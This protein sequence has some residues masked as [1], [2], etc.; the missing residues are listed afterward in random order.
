MRRPPGFLDGAPGGFAGDAGLDDAVDD[1]GAGDAEVC[2][3][4]Q[5]ATI[6]TESAIAP[7]RRRC[8]GS[9]SWLISLEYATAP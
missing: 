2:G 1:V 5:D 9:M 6:N 7:R 4:A 8:G 3:L